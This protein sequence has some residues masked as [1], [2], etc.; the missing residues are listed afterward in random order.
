MI[1]F[2]RVKPRSHTVLEQRFFNLHNTLRKTLS[3]GQKGFC[4][5]RRYSRMIGEEKVF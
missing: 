4:V 5:K 1:G 3:E 2:D